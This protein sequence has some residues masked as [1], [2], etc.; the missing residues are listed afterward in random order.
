MAG[1]DRDTKA[2][3][4]FHE[5]NELGRK[6]MFG[7]A[8]LSEQDYKEVISLAKEGVLSRS[9]IIEL[10]RELRDISSR[11]FSSQLNWEQLYEQTSDFLQALKLAPQS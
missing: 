1:T 5:L 9:K 8:K 7:K 2:S 11:L 10:T 6:K 4:T 3:K